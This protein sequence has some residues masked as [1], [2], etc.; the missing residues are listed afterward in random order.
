VDV[1]ERLVARGQHQRIGGGVP[2]LH[3]GAGAEP[4]DTAVDLQPLGE[5]A[6]RLH[7]A[8]ADDQQAARAV[9]ERRQAFH[10]R[11]EALALEAAAGEQC[12]PGVGRHA[13]LGPRGIPMPA[14]VVGVKA[15]EIHTVVDDRQ[16][17]VGHAVETRDLTGALPRDRDDL[18][19]GGKDAPFERQEHAMVGRPPPPPRR[20]RVQVRAMASFARPVHVL[21]ERPLV[22]LHGVPRAPPDRQ[23]H[24]QR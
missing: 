12:N 22:A 19:R 20:Q 23:P 1:A 17:R 21:A 8:L 24:G 18:G 16:P 5:P 15:R 11:G 4:G 9:A 10:R 7:V 2:A 3:V 14:T 6:V 13:G